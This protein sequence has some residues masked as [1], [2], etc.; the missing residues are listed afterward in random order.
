MRGRYTHTQST[1]YTTT[2]VGTRID[3]STSPCKEFALQVVKTGTVS[4]WTV[5][6]EVSL[7]G[8][9]FDDVLTHTEAD[10]TG[11]IQFSGALQYPSLWFRS[12]CT[13]FTGTGS[14]TA[15]ILG[16]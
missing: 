1:V 10:L 16:V 14:V 6:L 5:I 4:A 15:T 11:Q 8:T 12:T 3:C 2:A 13:I 7:N 9:D